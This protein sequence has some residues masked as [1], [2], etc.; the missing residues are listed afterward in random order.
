MSMLLPLKIQNKV[1]LSRRKK[2]QNIL[3][4]EWKKSRIVRIY[5][6]RLLHQ[7]NFEKTI[8]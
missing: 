3:R 1:R 4:K 6:E 7:I 8:R 5:K 2:K